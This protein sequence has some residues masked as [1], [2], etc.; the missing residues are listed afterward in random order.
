MEAPSY[1][2]ACHRCKASNQANSDK[3]TSCGF[4]AIATAKDIEDA[5]GKPS[6]RFTKVGVAALALLIFAPITFVLKASATKIPWWATVLIA[7]VGYCIFTLV[8]KGN[9]NGR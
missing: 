2:W 6:F 8:A 1:V 5:T 7:L 9:K 3:C 4:P